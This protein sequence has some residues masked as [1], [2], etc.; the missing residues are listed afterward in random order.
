M[1]RIFPAGGM[2]GSLFPLTLVTDKQRLAT[3]RHT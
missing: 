3:P 2:A 1:K